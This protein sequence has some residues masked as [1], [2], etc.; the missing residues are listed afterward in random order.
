MFQHVLNIYILK[1]EQIFENIL[2]AIMRF[3]KI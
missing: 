2:R 3:D 1:N